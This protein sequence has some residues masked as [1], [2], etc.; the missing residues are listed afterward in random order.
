[1]A[2]LIDSRNSA[3]SISTMIM[4]ENYGFLPYSET[5]DNAF[6]T[7]LVLTSFSHG[8]RKVII[9]GMAGLIDSRNSATSISTTFR[10]ENLI[11]YLALR[12]SLMHL[13]LLRKHPTRASGI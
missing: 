9:S 12:V 2:G 4:S 11:P 6:T 10:S 13:Q 8:S 3:T 7:A 1:M 5:F